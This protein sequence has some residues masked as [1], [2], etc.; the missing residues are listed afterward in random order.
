MID[1]WKYAL[2]PVLG[3]IIALLPNGYFALK[4][5]LNRHRQAKFIVRSFYAGETAKIM[6][7]A[8]LFAMVLQIPDINFLTLMIGY[9]S[10]LS[11]FWLALILWRD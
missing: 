3:S 6:L 7:T 5:Y 10:V 1:G 11:V 8:A 4:M 2:S 9:L